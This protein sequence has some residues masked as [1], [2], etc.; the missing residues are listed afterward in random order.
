[1][2]SSAG[3]AGGSDYARPVAG[4]SRPDGECGDV[5]WLTE[6]ERLAWIDVV[7]VL[8]RLPYRLD[9]DL[10]RTSQL[11]HFEYLVLSV[12]SEVPEHEVPMTRLAVLANSSPS[13][14]SH[15]VS[16]LEGRGWVQRA[17]S[18][19]D[20]RVKLVRLTELGFEVLRAAAPAHVGTV[21]ELVFDVLSAA[22]V[23]QFRV[24]CR[25]ILDRVDSGSEWPPVPD[26]GGQ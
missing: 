3:A 4:R 15:V 11:S 2:C 5:R 24:I 26:R 6:A 20:G 1:V 16:R 17:E 7:G 19:T 23:E 21:R 22:E 25:R 9:A 14:L 18:V 12:I 13:R 10:R 8:I